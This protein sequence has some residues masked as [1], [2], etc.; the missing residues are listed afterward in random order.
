MTIDQIKKILDEFIPFDEDDL[1]NDNESY[2]YELTEKLKENN[3]GKTAIENIFLLLEKYPNFDFGSP[4]PLVHTLES[5]K[6]DYENLLIESLNRKPT[7]MTVWMLNRII[8]GTSSAVERVKYLNIMK[9]LL[10]NPMIDSSTNED[11]I[12]FLKYQSAQ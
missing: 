1:E 3:N 11:I 4:G 10:K 12:D 7:P 5:F 9:D 8:N 2:L 6:G